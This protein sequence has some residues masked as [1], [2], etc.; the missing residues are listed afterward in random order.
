MFEPVIGIEIHCEL[1]TNTKM[2]SG[3]K[4]LYDQTPNTCVN[5]IDISMPGTL[6][7]L[8]KQAVKYAVMLSKALNMEIDPIIRFD[9]KN[10]YYS[11]LPKG[12]QITQQFFPLGQNG[13]V[14]IEVNDTIKRI[15]INRL[16]MEEDTAKQFHE[17]D[18][19]LIDFNRAGTP[20]LEIV[21]EADFRSGEEVAAYVN[22][23]RQLV[24]YLGIS[25][26]KM[27][28][29]SFRCDVNISLRPVGTE[30]FGT[31]VE[32]KNMN[33][34]ANIQ[35]AIEFEIKRQKDLLSK[36]EAVVS[37][38]LRYDDTTQTNIP[39]RSKESSVDYRYFVEPN[40][41]PTRIP[42]EFI[43]EPLSELPHDKRKRFM[44]TYNL[45]AYDID[46][47]M[48]NLELTRYFESLVDKVDNPKLLINWLTQDVISLV[49]EK[50]GTIESWLN[51]DYF[52]SFL[53]ALSRKEINSKQA[54]E[55][56]EAMTNGE[57]P[58]KVI[59]DR[60][61]MQISDETTLTNW[62]LEVLNENP[63][64][65]EDYRNGLDKSIKFVVG[66]VMKVSKGKANPALVNQIVIRELD[67]QKEIQ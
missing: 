24:V 5:E 17:N 25:D 14:D 42:Q 26:G 2:F 10:Y 35:K 32:I 66:Q 59:K 38:T 49:N 15:R 43:D 40:I 18:Q 67:K 3:A 4:V 16:H 31:K 62:V 56:F 46:V 19:T 11:D 9:R 7:S 41:L 34:V 13:Y 28:E 21:T 52:L 33:S 8:N 1:L 51:P 65:I 55:V 27:N 12:Y 47:L 6:P 44:D 45:G 23:L 39:M 54:K 57:D 61:M 37:Q 53:G 36:G 63:S 60:G 64:I 20:L 58:L 30:K 50:E 29:G 48:G 22:W